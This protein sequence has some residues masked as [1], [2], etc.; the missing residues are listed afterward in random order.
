MSSYFL[1]SCLFEDG[2]EV[3]LV[4]TN[5]HLMKRGFRIIS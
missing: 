2:H 1:E 4:A 5:Y 3:T